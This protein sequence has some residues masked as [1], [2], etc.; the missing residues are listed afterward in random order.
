M[1]FVTLVATVLSATV[2]GDIGGTVADSA[3]GTPL[4]GGEVRIVQGGNLIATAVTDAFGRYVLHNLRPER[5]ASRSGI[6]GIAP[7]RT[8]CPSGD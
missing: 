7:R 8:I 1:H 4:A 5:I 2:G 3:T 6:W